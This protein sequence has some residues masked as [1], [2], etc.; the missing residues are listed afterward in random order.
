[1]D[2]DPVLAA[3]LVALAGPRRGDRVAAVGVSDLVARA[4]LAA[5]GPQPVAGPDATLVVLGRAHE[6][7]TGLSLLAAGGRLVCVAAD[8]AAAQRSADALGL[9]LL[10]VEPIGPG[11]AWSARRPGL[12]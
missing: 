11:V 6:L 4:L 8:P 12:P 2:P 10:H 9:V 1:M 3:V 5:A 7:P